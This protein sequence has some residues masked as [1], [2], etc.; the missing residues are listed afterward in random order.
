[1]KKLSNLPDYPV[2]RGV[3]LLEALSRDFS[4]QVIRIYR[5]QSIMTLK[6][7]EFCVMMQQS[8]ELFSTW[9]EEYKSYK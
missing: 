4:V 3:Q 6:Y 5:G 1:M 7:S 8:T 2:Q 9:E